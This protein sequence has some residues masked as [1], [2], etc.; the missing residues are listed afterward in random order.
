MHSWEGGSVFQFRISPASNLLFAVYIGLRDCNFHF[1]CTNLDCWTGPSTMARKTRSIL[2]LVRRASCSWTLT[3]HITMLGVSSLEVSLQRVRW[4]GR[5]SFKVIG[6]GD[7]R[8]CCRYSLRYYL[9]FGSTTGLNYTSDHN[10]VSCVVSA[11]ISTLGEIFVILTRSQT[12]LYRSTFVAYTKRQ[13]R[14][15]KRNFDTIPQWRW[16]DES[17]HRGT[18]VCLIAMWWTTGNLESTTAA[19]TRVSG[20]YQSQEIGTGEMV[21]HLRC[22]ES[23]DI[24]VLGLSTSV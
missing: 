10:N 9:L 4:W 6:L 13:I 21:V 15:G 7:C 24:V 8:Y 11:R 12:D 22:P 14:R 1:S 19:I 17:H 18:H 23:W 20:V 3:N 2:Q 5:W 16:S